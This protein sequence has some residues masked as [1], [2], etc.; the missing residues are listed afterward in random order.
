MKLIY[1]IFRLD[2]IFLLLHAFMPESSNDQSKYSSSSLQPI[3]NFQFIEHLRANLYV[4]H[5]RESR[6]VLHDYNY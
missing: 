3:A 5:T 6:G 2:K 4:K 1:S